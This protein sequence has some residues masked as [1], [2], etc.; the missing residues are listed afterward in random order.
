MHTPPESTNAGSKTRK[1]VFVALQALYQ[2]W[3][4]ITE[5]IGQST[6]EGVHKADENTSERL[7]L[8]LKS[9]LAP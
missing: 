7:F 9:R 1:A 4:F 6:R 8:R 3:N 5:R 2:S